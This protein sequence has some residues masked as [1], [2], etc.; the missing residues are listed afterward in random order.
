MWPI[1]ICAVIALVLLGS[2]SV[3]RE[4][5]TQCVG[6][7]CDVYFVPSVML[8]LA[9]LVAVAVTGVLAVSWARP[10]GG[11]WVAILIVTTALGLVGPPVTLLIFRD[12]PDSLVLV[13]TLLLVQGPVAALVYSVNQV[14]NRIP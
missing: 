4:I 1:R 7:Q 2:F 8:P 6:T 5:A 13:A 12:H 9:T 10:V 3:L 14:P 11:A